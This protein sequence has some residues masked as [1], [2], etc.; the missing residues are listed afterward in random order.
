MLQPLPVSALP[1]PL[2]LRPCHSQPTP[3]LCLAQVLWKEDRAISWGVGEG[4]G[5]LG[6]R[7]I[8]DAHSHKKQLLLLR[9]IAHLLRV[10]LQ[11][12]APM[13]PPPEA[14]LLPST[15]RRVLHSPTEKIVPLGT[16]SWA[17]GC[18]LA[19]ARTL[20]DTVTSGSPSSHAVW[21]EKMLCKAVC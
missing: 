12:L 16:L 14:V 17:C 10:G 21:A 11:Y 5:W 8:V 13:S 7:R 15:E 1:P 4:G 19:G 18:H 20:V 6:I 2:S 9:R 3:L